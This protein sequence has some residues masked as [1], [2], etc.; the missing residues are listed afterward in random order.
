MSGP[1]SIL[2]FAEPGDLGVVNLENMASTLSLETA[3][4]L[5]RYGV[6]FDFLQAAA[7][8]QRI[9]DMLMALAEEM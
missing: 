5:R 9:P 4:D 3:D 8:G 7:L 2:D 1:F 6:A